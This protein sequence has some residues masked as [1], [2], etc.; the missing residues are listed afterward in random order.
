MTGIVIEPDLDLFSGFF[1]DPVGIAIGG[2]N[3]FASEVVRSIF[4]MRKKFN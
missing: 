4:I 3:G 1:H 2:M